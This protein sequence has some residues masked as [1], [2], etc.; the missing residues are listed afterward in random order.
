MAQAQATDLL[1]EPVTA[2]ARAGK[3]A[4]SAAEI[5]APPPSEN[6]D[7]ATARLAKAFDTLEARI[8]QLQNKPQEPSPAKAAFTALE[9]KCARLEADC[10]ELFDQRETLKKESDQQKAQL[11]LAESGLAQYRQAYTAVSGRVE[12]AIAKLEQLLAEPAE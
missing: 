12:S 6:I 11:T 2:S 8:R 1:E 7:V 4:P 9:E 10:S 5:S 3:K